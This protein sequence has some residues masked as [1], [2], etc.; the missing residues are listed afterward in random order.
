MEQPAST[1]VAVG[2]A[3]NQGTTRNTRKVHLT[4]PMTGEATAAHSMSNAQIVRGTI[5]A[6][7]GTAR[8]ASI[9]GKS[10]R[11]REIYGMVGKT[12]ATTSTP[13]TAHKV[14]MTS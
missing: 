13:V 14:M 4:F 2:S 10:S 8:E 11:R 6:T 7:R 9:I 1:N 12:T 5:G 3:A